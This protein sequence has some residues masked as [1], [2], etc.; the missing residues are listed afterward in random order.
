M[1]PTLADLSPRYQA[2]VAAQLYAMPR[3]RTVAIQVA[4]IAPARPKRKRADSG[5]TARFFAL[6]S[7]DGIVQPTTEHRFVP[8]RRWRFDFAWIAQKV[9]LE[10]EGGVWTGGRHTRG[11]GFL[12]DCEKYN[13]GA[14]EGW[15]ILRV[16]PS[17]LC[18]RETIELIRRALKSP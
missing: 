4:E 2:Q 15:A 14:V 10:V 3:P 1:K 6:L 9:A 12:G 7:R 11:A 18:S 17:A 5:A 8:D 16:T 13:R